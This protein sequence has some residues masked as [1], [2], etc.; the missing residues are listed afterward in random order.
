M[1]TEME[2]GNHTCHHGRGSMDMEN[3]IERREA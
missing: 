1:E 2:A 3:E